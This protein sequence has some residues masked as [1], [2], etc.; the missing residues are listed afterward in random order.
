MVATG[1]VGPPE[2]SSG[3]RRAGSEPSEPLADRIRGKVEDRGRWAPSPDVLLTPDLVPEERVPRPQT[4]DQVFVHLLAV[5][6]C[7]MLGGTAA[8]DDRVITWDALLAGGDTGP[9]SVPEPAPAIAGGPVRIPG[10]MLPLETDER[11]VTEFL[12]VPWVGACIHAPR[13]AADQMIHVSVPEGT[14]IRDLFATVWV[15]GEIRVQPG[16]YDLFLVDGSQIVPA[17]YAMTADSISDYSSA[18]SDILANVEIPS[19][20]VDA[21]GVQ[22]HLHARVSQIFSQTMLDIRDQGGA[23]ALLIGILFAFLYGALHTFGPGHGK[24]VVVSYFVGEGGSLARGIGMGTRIAVFHVLSAIV[25]VMLTDLA[26]RQATGRA[27][28]DYRA[29]QL[30]SYAGIAAI[31]GWMLFSA[32]KA[33]RGGSG[34]PEHTGCV[35]CSC[36]TSKKKQRAGG[37]LAVAIGAVPCTGAMLVL[38]FGMANDLLWPAILMVIAISAGMAMAL[39]AVGCLAILGRRAVD[40]RLSGDAAT[41]ARITGF[42]RLAAAA[43]VVTVGATLFALAWSAPTA[44]GPDTLDRAS[45]SA[46]AAGKS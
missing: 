15:D 27:P 29:I 8:A 31:G 30:I 43:T 21:D 14:E 5:L 17:T 16:E 37:V 20:G 33:T 18:E 19:D 6:I 42:L 2:A 3:H 36:A 46:S 23:R 35:A 25:V 40:D 1:D 7:L 10:H 11:G 34:D 32:I 38:L 39:S 45:A 4:R 9:G 13:P 12:L 44:P 22:E 28:S 41:H 26:V 24:T